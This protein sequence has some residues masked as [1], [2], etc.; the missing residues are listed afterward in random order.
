MKGAAPMNR[1]TMSAILVGV[2]G[3][4]SFTSATAYGGTENGDQAAVVPGNTEFALDL[5]GR[6]RSEE[7]NLFLSPYSISTALAMT[8]AGARGETARQMADV[9]HFTLEPARLH[10]AFGTLE[11]TIHEA[12][13]S[14]GCTVSLAN[15]LWGQQGDG[16][17]EE[18]LALNR[19]C[20]GAG[21]HE[22]DFSGAVEEARKTINV[23]VEEQTEKLI[24]ELLHK[25]DLDPS[26]SLVLTNAIYFKGLWKRP[27]DPQKTADAPFHTDAA[28]TVTVPMMM[29]TEAF[30]VARHDELDVLEM[31]YGG[32]R[33]AMVVLLPTAVD[34]LPAVEKLLSAKQLERW[35]SEGRREEFVHVRIPRCKLDFRAGLAG[36]L[37]ALGMT[38][39]FGRSA[40]FSGMNG[41]RDLFIGNVIH[42]A[43]VDVNEEGTE[44]AAATAV[45]MLKGPPPARFVADHPFLFLIRDTQ[46]GTILFIGRVVNPAGA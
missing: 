13:A 43:K 34:G 9:L 4:L 15:A 25:G 18:F 12:G 29:Q 39:A 14:P 44:A 23:W 10:P 42:Q 32:N 36:T 6:L 28:H 20:Y 40:D 3:G 27:F 16:F 26:P 33:L 30:H 21:F 41:Q 19:R 37:K 35:L 38:D 5:Y 31:P 2:T 8:Y 24:R 22:V 17:L 11:A 45:T 1:R 7:G 46:T